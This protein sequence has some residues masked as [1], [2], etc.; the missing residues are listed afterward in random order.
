MLKRSSFKDST[1]E[2]KKI[3]KKQSERKKFRELFKNKTKQNFGS[4]SLT[5]F[6]WVYRDEKGMVLVSLSFLFPPFCFFL[7][8]PRA[9]ELSRGKRRAG[10]G[11]AR[12]AAG[13]AGP[14]TLLPRMA[15]AKP[16]G[17]RNPQRQLKAGGGSP[18]GWVAARPSARTAPSP[19]LQRKSVGLR[20]RFPPTPRPGRHPPASLPPRRGE[21]PR[22][23]TSYRSTASEGGLRTT[24]RTQ[25]ARRRRQRW[26]LA[27][28]F[29][30]EFPP[31]SEAFV[32]H[33]HPADPR[34]KCCLRSPPGRLVAASVSFSV[35][36]RPLPGCPGCRGAHPRSLVPHLTPHRPPRDPPKREELAPGLE[37]PLV[38]VWHLASPSALL[39][40]NP[41][42]RIGWGRAG[43]AA[44]RGSSG[45]F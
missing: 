12:E 30:P 9:M 24:A 16:P 19:V 42:V 15:R 35:T 28:E 41:G 40:I 44:A 14:A 1:L 22:P 11:G 2:K 25:A 3:I 36:R 34:P 37:R 39:C 32:F 17:W 13:P 43:W 21:K 20:P 23:T 29:A 38:S 26:I 45:G 27:R 18:R 10:L 31:E 4:L 7:F 5:P 6:I 8:Y 33:P